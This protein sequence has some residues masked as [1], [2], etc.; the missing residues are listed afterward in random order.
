[1]FVFAL[2]LFIEIFK[3]SNDSNNIFIFVLSSVNCEPLSETTKYNLFIIEDAAE[4]HGAEYKGIKTG[5]L[6]DIT[7]FSFFANKN[8][9]TG[10]GGMVVTNSDILYKKAKYYKNLCF[11]LEGPRNYVHDDI[12]FNY[13]MSNIHAAIG[14]A[15]IEKAD[16]YIN[17][18]ITNAN[19]YKQYL[20]F[21]PGIFFQKTEEFSKHVHWMNS[22]IVNHDLYGR[23]KNEL[24]EHL[25]NNGIETRNLFV[26]MNKQPSLIKYGI[27]TTGNYKN[28]ENLTNNGLYLPSSTNISIDNIQFICNVIK[29][30]KK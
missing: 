22:I 29:K 10:E 11:P 28:T 18:R 20:E 24:Q 17:M 21:V 23:S 6:A 4:S 27:I 19:L 7:T 14:V 16:Y 26:G 5:N 3:Y 2:N 25:K 12:G 13:R 8:L 9:T 30:F 15:Q 1:M